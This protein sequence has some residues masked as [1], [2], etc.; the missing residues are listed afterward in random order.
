MS[1]METSD[2]EQLFIGSPIRPTTTELKVATPKTPS[3]PY[4]LSDSEDDD[5]LDTNNKLDSLNIS[6]TL[7]NMLRYT[8]FNV[9]DDDDDDTALFST[10]SI[11]KTPGALESLIAKKDPVQSTQRSR[12]VSAASPLSAEKSDKKSQI[13]KPRKKKAAAPKRR[14]GNAEFKAILAKV[15]QNNASSGTE[16]EG[17]K[18]A[19]ALFEKK[20]DPK[21]K[22]TRASKTK[23]TPEQEE[24]AKTERLKKVVKKR[25]EKGKMAATE[26]NMDN[27][28]EALFGSTEPGQ[29]EPLDSIMRLLKKKSTGTELEPDLPQATGASPFLFLDSDDESEEDKPSTQKRKSLSKKAI[30]EMRRETE[31]SQRSIEV[32]LQPRF[33]KKTFSSFLERSENPSRFQDRPEERVELDSFEERQ[34]APTTNSTNLTDGQDSRQFYSDSDSDLEIIGGPKATPAHLLS[35]QRNPVVTMAWSPVRTSRTT[36]RDM[37]KQLQ[38]RI[39]RE[40][41]ERRKQMEEKARARGSFTTAEERAKQLLE[42]EKEAAR[43][44][45]EVDKHFMKTG[46]V[47]QSGD[48]DEDEE[49]GDYEEGGDEK[50]EDNDVEDIQYSGEEDEDGESEL[51][52]DDTETN[53]NEAKGGLDAENSSDEEVGL[54]AINRKRRRNKKNNL[55]EDD[56]VQKPSIPTKKPEPKNSI[57]NFFNN[58]KAKTVT[59]SDTIDT[60]NLEDVTE[61]S[62]KP[63]SRLI[64]RTVELDSS[65][66]EMNVEREESEEEDENRATEPKKPVLKSVAPKG[67]KEKSEYVEEEAQESEDEFFGQGGPEADENDENLDEYEQDGLLV[68]RNEETDQMDEGV[69]RAVFN[70]DMEERDK[71]MTQRLVNDITGGGLRRRLAAK[72]AGLMLEDYDFYDDDDM[73]L[74]AIRRAASAKRRKMLQDGGNQLEALAKD[75]KTAAFAKA[76][77]PL[78]K[79]EEMLLLSDGEEEPE[80]TKDETKRNNLGYDDDEEDEDEENEDVGDIEEEY[81]GNEL[82]RAE[83][84][85][86]LGASRLSGGDH[87]REDVVYKNK[88]YHGSKDDGDD[89]T[90]RFSAQVQIETKR[91]GAVTE[92]VTGRTNPLFKSP[93]RLERFHGLLSEANG[94]IGGSSDT[95]SR[96]G[97]GAPQQK[98]R[99]IGKEYIV[100]SVQEATDRPQEKRNKR[101]LGIIGRSGSFT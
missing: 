54:P 14:S 5:N 45:M 85:N 79:D 40:M 101:L 64:K 81:D 26:N 77:M 17:E 28:D 84:A 47:N 32:K 35:P 53:Q 86:L 2:D 23:K 82:F 98:E 16:S 92:K 100:G 30:L 56:E 41:L 21:P 8:N 39:A 61:K 1:A 27:E 91:I 12:L 19:M 55:L 42:R 46:N 75:P 9:D 6:S 57:T 43:I 20:V 69:L 52:E 60:D 3:K 11:I 94:M 36:H 72:E 51:D 93:G 89:W 15:M 65:D 80:E 24:K 96:K 31:R 62:N 99:G 10:P 90:V 71:N 48:D 18:E 87:D 7:K 95:G 38:E 68:E 44:K 88:L 97:F 63:L 22:K 73:D 70:K 37:N 74:V 59:F 29:V 78:L 13:K 4:D 50:E 83:R 33:K 34:V 67:P 76:A 66:T 25:V 49:D 58:Q